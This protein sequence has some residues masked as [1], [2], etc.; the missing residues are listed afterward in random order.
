MQKLVPVLIDGTSHPF[1]DVLLSNIEP[2]AGSIAHLCWC[3]HF[4]GDCD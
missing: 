2:N 3:T 4:A 1:E